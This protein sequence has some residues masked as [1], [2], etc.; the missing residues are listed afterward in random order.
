MPFKPDYT[1]LEKSARNIEVKRTPLYEHQIAPSIMEKVLG[2][3]FE[4]LL[5]G[6]FSEKKEFFRHFC[7][8]FLKMGYDTVSF[9][10]II[11][12]IMPGSGALYHHAEGVI[13]TRED[14]EAYPWE[15]I[16]DLFFTKYGDCFDALREMLPEGMKAAGGPGNGVFE[17]VQ[18]VVGYQNLCYISVDEPELF[19][20]L[21]A[22]TG[23]I[24]TRIWQRFIPLYGDI[25]C[26][27]RFGDD[28]GYKSNTLLAADD[29]KRLVLPQYKKVVDL[30]HQAGKPFLL[31]SCGCIFDLME[32]LIEEVGID[33]KHS[34]EDQIAPFAEWVKRY[35]SR[36]GN[37]GGMDTDIVCR[38]SLSDIR[39][40]VFR[41]MESCRGQG[42]FAFGTGNSVPDYTPVESYIAMIEAVREARGE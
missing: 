41:I 3:R 20:D 10:G 17:C 28:L 8:F 25:Y 26:V 16:P 42:G 33:A 35:G 37:F 1:H 4:D 21:F 24:I 12:G 6:D 11:S 13:K 31:H 22:R 9:E 7:N 34:N 2:R 5:Q 15:E 36:I 38:S 23:E 29:L 14:F 30:V 27:L 32:P 39:D 18:D 19:D 40:Y